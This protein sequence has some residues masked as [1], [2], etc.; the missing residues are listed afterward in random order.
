MRVG[1]SHLGSP[2][3]S[4]HVVM[5]LA[6]LR[7]AEGEG[8]EPSRARGLVPFRAGCHRQLACPSVRVWMAGFEPAWSG[9]RGRRMGPGSPTSR[10]EWDP[11]DSNPHLAG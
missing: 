3:P 10:L 8:V 1:Y 4:R 11:R 6:T 7:A 9:F 5:R 2:M